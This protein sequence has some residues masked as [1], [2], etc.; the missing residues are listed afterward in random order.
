MS[1]PLIGI[2]AYFEAA[3]WG[4]WVREAVLS[5]PS[6]AKAV[7]RAGARPWCCR[8]WPPA[9]WTTTYAG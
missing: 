9:P 4:D 7:G 6:Y 3:R 1:R 8:P 2:T 5:P